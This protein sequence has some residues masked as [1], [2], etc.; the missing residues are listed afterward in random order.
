MNLTD[1]MNFSYL[2]KK[3][4]SFGS[5]TIYPTHFKAHSNHFLKKLFKKIKRKG[6][7]QT[8]SW[9][10]LSQHTNRLL[11]GQTNKLL[12]KDRIWLQTIQNSSI[13][14][15]PT[16]VIAEAGAYASYHCVSSTVDWTG[17]QSLTVGTRRTC[18]YR[19]IYR[20]A[21]LC[22]IMP[23]ATYSLAKII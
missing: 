12:L 7:S 9:F 6:D 17:C 5:Q 13:S 20:K 16:E 1:L 22:T 14:I 4:K 18:K 23:P 10:I 19:Y 3:K 15:H 11:G 2:D 8:I 21:P